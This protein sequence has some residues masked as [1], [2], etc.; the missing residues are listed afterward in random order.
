[1]SYGDLRGCAS[2]KPLGTVTDTVK[3]GYCPVRGSCWSLKT[4]LGSWSCRGGA[5]GQPEEGLGSA[6]VRQGGAGAGL[7]SRAGLWGLIPGPILQ[8][9]LGG[10][11]LPPQDP[12]PKLHCTHTVLGQASHL[13]RTPDIP[14]S[15]VWPYS[16]TY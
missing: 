5:S 3:A 9:L 7:Y 12:H 1:M 6:Q 13:P 10:G 14:C 11:R 2:H 15:C 8:A 4:L 16:G